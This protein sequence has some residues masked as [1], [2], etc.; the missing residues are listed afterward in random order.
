MIEL[1]AGDRVLAGLTYATVLP[2]C[3]CETWSEA[4]W[5]WAL[6]WAD[7]GGEV[8]GRWLPPPGV[9]SATGAGLSAA[10]AAKYAAHPT[11]EVLTFSYDLKDGRGER[12]WRPGEPPPFDL[13]AHVGGG[14]LLESH[15][16]G[17]EWWV[18]LHVLTKRYGW[19]PLP[20]R[21]QRCSM[22]KA[23]A[24]GLPGALGK[25]AE[26]LRADVQ[27]DKAGVDLMKQFSMPRQPTKT[28]RRRRCMP[29]DDPVSFVRYRNYCGTDIATESAISLRI[30]DLSPAEQEWWEI[31]QLINRRGVQVDMPSVSAGIAIMEQAFE[32]YNT[33]LFRITDG[34]V[35][36]ASELQ[37]L[38]EWLRGHGVYMD[39]MDEDALAEALKMMP[40]GAP[41]RA[42]EIRQ[43]VGSAS[44]KKLYAIYNQATDDGRLHDLYIFHGARTGRP[45]GDGPQPTNLPK[46]KLRVVKCEGCGRHS[47]GGHEFCPWCNACL[48]GVDAIDWEQAPEAAVDVLAVVAER[49]L[50]RLEHFFGDAFLTLSGSLRSIFCAGPGCELVS[51]DYSAIEAVVL[52]ELAGETWRQELFR[53]GGKI[54]EASGA[55]IQGL[56]YD[57]VIEHKKRTGS[58]H[59]CRKVGKVAELA[60][61]YQGWIGA[62]KAFG[63]DEF[64]T[65]D[66][67][68]ATILAWRKASPMIVRM[69]G[70]QLV[71]GL[72]G[73][74][75]VPWCPTATFAPYGLEGAAIQAV[76][77]P[78]QEFA[79]RSIS[80]RVHDDV[81]YCRLPSG[82]HIAYHT[83]RLRPSART[84]G[85]YS[86]SYWGWNTN[87]KNGAVGW[88]QMD[89]W[90]GKLTENVVQA[91]ARDIFR[92]AVVRLWRAG[93]Y[94]V[95]HTYDEIAAEIP[96]GWGSIEEFERLMSEMPA[97]AQGWPIFAVDGWR[98]ERYRKG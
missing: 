96:K 33:E 76:L 56:S 98:G 37:K 36:R 38:Q 75:C 9:S 23:R 42:L 64:M 80:Y 10:G 5:V 15:N 35:Q 3:D 32:R 1:R 73:E 66:E 70:G 63:A 21:Q 83:P 53:N 87:P 82:R 8:L 57:D 50:D 29:E 17:F 11:C 93:Y 91:V 61:G 4:G 18:W 89:T 45:T 65:D 94:T 86:L 28:D 14:G 74:P 31:D 95:L 72:T 58:H 40:S 13:W 16:A 52:A 78:G 60:G 41:R 27:K 85:T 30:P 68:K 55:R 44:V 47:S 43:R 39:A 7:K 84:E 54:Y 25:I 6:D 62:Y 90:G 51:S 12:R 97:W 77:N 34:A 22:A 88:V 69:W 19:P 46:G 71:D 59:P 49:N 67:I 48:L 2:D 24:W 79:Y 26:V 92:D 81:L 20:T